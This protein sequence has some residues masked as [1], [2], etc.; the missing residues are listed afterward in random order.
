MDQKK[1]MFAT[2]DA[3]EM[4]QEAVAFCWRCLTPRPAMMFVGDICHLCANPT[5]VPTTFTQEELLA[6]RHESYKLALGSLIRHHRA[7][8]FALVA[9]EQR[10]LGITD[11]VI[12]F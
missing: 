12:R 4:E 11:E 10:T 6:L 5:P 9:N 1:P 8:F 2:L 3:Y 7:E